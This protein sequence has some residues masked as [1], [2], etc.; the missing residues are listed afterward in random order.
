MLKLY[1]NLRGR[2]RNKREGEGMKTLKQAEIE[3]LSDS[4]N[5]S[6]IE[7]EIAAIS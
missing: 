6:N 1:F 2:G 3:T 7:N 4:L 5:I